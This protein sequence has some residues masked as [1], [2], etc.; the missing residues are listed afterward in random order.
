MKNKNNNR[1]LKAFLI[2]C[3]ISFLFS[4][5]KP[6]YKIHQKQYES[7]SVIYTSPIPDY[8]KLFY[9]AAHPEKKDPSD[10]VP[11][12]IPSSKKTLQADVF[13]IH[14]TTLT[15][16]STEGFIWNAALNDASLNLKTDFTSILYQAS[17]FNGS[18]RVFAPRYR[19]AHIYSFKTTDTLRAIEA[20]ELAYTDIREAFLHYLKNENQG[21]PIIIASHSQG[22]LH[23][24]RLLKEFFDGKDLKNQLVCAYLLG[25]TLPKGEYKDIPVC[26]SDTS[27]GCYVGWRTFR[28]GYIPEY[29][30]KENFPV[31]VVNPLSWTTDVNPVPR[32]KN[33]SA[34]LFRFNKPYPKTNGAGIVKNV[35]WIEK[36]RFPF[37]FLDHRKNYHAGDI[38]LF[39]MN[40]RKNVEK[41]I[42]SFLR[43]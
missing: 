35:L 23:A 41:R 12:T 28:K 31:V 4:A 27:T 14:P 26:E 37:S 18:S 15:D 7:E 29:I 5:C 16:R 21:R 32:S 17:V 34:V 24:R 25:L 22:T 30:E 19:Q 13:F 6:T 39:Y 10:S 40:I 9:W 20:F 42:E 11:A 8:S 1:V 3:F 2:I 33:E 43:K 38:N 36:P